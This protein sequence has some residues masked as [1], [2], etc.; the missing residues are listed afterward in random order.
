[1]MGW[2]CVFC[3][4]SCSGLITVYHI[5]GGIPTHTCTHLGCLA[6]AVERSSKMFPHVTDEWRLI[7]KEN[8]G[9]K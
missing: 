7:E 9:D 2:K 4:G 8:E 3:G 5:G 1:M 6:D